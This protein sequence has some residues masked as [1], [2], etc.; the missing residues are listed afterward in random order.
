MTDPENINLFQK[1]TFLENWNWNRK[2]MHGLFTSLHRCHFEQCQGR[3][4]PHNIQSLQQNISFLLP[5]KGNFFCK[6]CV[7][8][9]IPRK[10]D[11][12]ME[13]GG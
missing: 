6:I 12:Y 9:Q 7:F 2:D 4:Y 11:K 13:S 10:E 1:L 8:C 3:F 5:L